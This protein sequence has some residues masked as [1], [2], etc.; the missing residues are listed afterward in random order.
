MTTQKD[1]WKLEHCPALVTIGVVSGKWKTK[2]LW[3]LREDNMQFGQLR[4]GLKGI[5]AK[6]L[7]EH[8]KQLEQDG[9]IYREVVVSNKV[10]VSNYGYTDYG[11][12]LIPVLD[13]MG[14]WGLEHESRTELK[15]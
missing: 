13:S 7:T 10:A 11:K 15:K 12:T 6:M 2:I 3:A 5:S 1:L 14:N 8:L 4:R 9:L